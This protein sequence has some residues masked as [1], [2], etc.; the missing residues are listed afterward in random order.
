MGGRPDERRLARSRQLWELGTGM[1]SGACF[2]P[3]FVCWKLSILPCLFIIKVTMKGDI[4]R[5]TSQVKQWSRWLS[6]LPW[7][8]VDWTPQARSHP[9]AGCRCRGGTSRGLSASCPVGVSQEGVIS[10]ALTIQAWLHCHF[11]GD[12]GRKRGRSHVARLSGVL[13]LE[14]LSKRGAAVREAA[15]RSSPQGRK[16]RADFGIRGWGKS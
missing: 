14:P 3:N 13:S 7:S 12:Q 15:W 16:G 2:V 4:E 5:E 8:A 11:H 1:G 9:F 6:G 10:V